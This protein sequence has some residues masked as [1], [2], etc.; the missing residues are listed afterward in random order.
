M[1]KAGAT[2][3]G[4]YASLDRRCDVDRYFIADGDENLRLAF[5]RGR[6]PQHIA[7]LAAL[8]SSD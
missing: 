4:S 5:V 3:L 8:E 1:R 2:Q 7:T 6:P